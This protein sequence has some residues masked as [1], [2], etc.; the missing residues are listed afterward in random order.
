M[1]NFY[2]IRVNCQLKK[3]MKY[4]KYV[5]NDHFV[6]VCLFLFGA[7]GYYY[8]DLLKTLPENYIYG[9]PIVGGVWFISLFIGRLA[10]LVEE[11]DKVF[12]LPK[13]LQ[14]KDYLAKAFRHSMWLPIGALI[15]ISGISMPLLVISTNNQFSSFFSYLVMLVFLKM[16]HMMIQK[17]KM[18]Q[19][20]VKTVNQ[21][22]LIWS[23]ATLLVIFISLYIVPFVGVILAILQMVLCTTL[24][25]KQEKRLA[26]DWEKMIQVEQARIY[27]IYQFIHLFT[28]VPEI[29]SRVKRRKYLDPL[30]IWVKKNH[31]NTFMYLYVHSFLR[32]SEYSG[33]FIRLVVIG[34]IILFFLTDFWLSLVLSL[35]FVYLIGF[36]LIPLYAQFD[37]MV[38][39]NLYPVSEKQKKQA[40]NR[41]ITI[42]LGIAA[43]VFVIFSSI[44]LADIQESGIILLALLVEVVLFANHYVP[45]RLKKMQVM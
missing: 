4:M 20:E 42:L 29:G 23:F 19:V 44:G 34:G 2:Q 16:S 5:L 33:L 17:Y 38:M 45:Q 37:Y 30:M 28:D 32:G 3:M 26:L 10:T 13:E 8:S 12:I 14:M 35:V 24:L 15:L 41:I 22:T 9:R 36:Q 43:F 31:E 7:F 39:T 27:R 1:D 40:V 21:I 6:L 11:A 25:G 18:Y